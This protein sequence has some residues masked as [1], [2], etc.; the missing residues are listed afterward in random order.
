[1]K[2]IPRRYPACL[3]SLFLTLSLSYGCAG[4]RA[5]PQ[6]AVPTDAVAA[7]QDSIDAI[8]Q[9]ST[10]R[11]T[12]AEVKVVSLATGEVLYQRNS[13]HLLHPASN[14]KLLTTLAALHY[15]TPSYTFQTILYAD[16]SAVG[17][18]VIAGDV[19]LKGYGDP[20]FSTE[21]L[22]GMVD[23]LLAMGIHRIE[24]DI[25]CDD[26]YFDSLRVG[27]GWMWD[28]GPVGGYFSPIS[29]IA[30]NSNT[31]EL[32]VGPGDSVGSPVRVQLLPSTHYVTIDNQATTAA[33]SDTAAEL[34]VHRARLANEIQIT[35][36]LRLNARAKSF[37]VDVVDPALY[38]GTVFREQLLS[39]GVQVEGQVR[40]GI[41]PDSLKP[42]VVHE[43]AP[44]TLVVY[45]T[46]KVSDNLS[47]EM[48]LK[49]VGAS[50][51]GPPGTAEK[52]LAAIRQ[53]FVDIGVDTSSFEL[54]DGSGV[55]RYN[56]IAPD[57]LVEW[58]R[59]AY[60]NPRLRPDFIAS[61]PIAGV[62]GT[63][64]DRM[65]GTAAQGVL[66]AKTGSLA[67]ISTLAGY[68]TTADGEPLA[69][70]MMF[71]NFLG[72]PDPIRD[73]QDRIGA[74]LTSFRRRLRAD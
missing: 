61:L 38:L 37:S 7:L 67:G 21:D 14:Q 63:L 3:L 47:A 48:L 44:L 74:L 55:S 33:E 15:L 5:L 17:D 66:R 32:Q 39:S 71:G 43:S 30:L 13:D 22:H 70:S 11:R 26:T 50:V 2:R 12:Y 60:Q 49:A 59:F 57:I 54:V 25:V 65:R 1:M 64:D 4:T 72:S 58:L 45:H 69:F 20:D 52:G 73:V 51:A 9:D 56:L 27:V 31:V 28:D 42:V 24:G 36:A 62:D 41:A 16:S 35:G 18:S 53:M 40:R 8:L 10:L 19:F 29:A 6:Q 68:T 34:E 23:R 46:N